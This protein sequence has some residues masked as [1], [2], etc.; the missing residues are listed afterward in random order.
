MSALI[1]RLGPNT[2]IDLDIFVGIPLSELL[3]L[4]HAALDEALATA[5]GIYGHDEQHIRRVRHL[6]CDRRGGGIGR[7]G[8]ASF[9]ATLVDV[10]DDRQWLSCEAFQREG[11]QY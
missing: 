11:R 4:G 7:N 1:D 2:A 6:V 5:S 9:H 3:D 10:L 8:K